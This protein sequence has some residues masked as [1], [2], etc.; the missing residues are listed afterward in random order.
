LHFGPVRG[1]YGHDQRIIQEVAQLLAS[2]AGR[3]NHLQGPMDGA[4]PCRRTGQSMHTSS[5]IVMVIL[6]NI[7]QM[8]EVTERTNHGIALVA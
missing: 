3:V 8:R 2:D 6:G 4:W 5:P 1:Q 7:Y